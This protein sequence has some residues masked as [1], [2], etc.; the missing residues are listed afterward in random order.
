MIYYLS[1]LRGLRTISLHLW[2]QLGSRLAVWSMKTSVT[3][4]ML[5]LM[6]LTAGCDPCN[7]CLTW[8]S[9]ENMVVEFKHLKFPW[10]KVLTLEAVHF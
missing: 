7:E 5:Y 1:Y 10:K 2:C 4:L 3:G 8:T 9:N 6:R